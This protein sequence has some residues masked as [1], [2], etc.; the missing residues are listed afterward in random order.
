VKAIIT[1]GGKGTRLYPISRAFPKELIPFCGI[2]VIEYGINLLK[3]N[4]IRDIIIVTGTKKGALQD[5]LG[6]GE[7]FGVNI[8][9][10]IQEQPKGLGHS[11][12]ITEPYIDN[13]N[14][15]LLLGDT[16]ITGE[17]DLKEMMNIHQKYNVSSTILIEHVKDPERYGVVKLDNDNK[18]I[19]SLYEKPKEQ[20]I[21]DQFKADNGWYTIAGLYIFNRNIFSFLKRTL[22]DSN[23]EIQLTDAIKLSLK[24][25]IV[26]G[27]ILKGKRIDV[28][29]W[30]YIRD[31]RRHYINMA[32]D[33]LENIIEIRN[34]KMDLLYRYMD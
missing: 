7:I 17:S 23:N 21:K 29:S 28:G 24:D 2:P 11:V 13:E 30:N 34:R 9:Y 18:K 5:Y 1:A 10:I 27:H 6:N 33:E 31:E 3:E 12:L 16:I 15:V 19:I 32:E 26:F 22:K 25:N 20:N 8:A 4:G 14:F